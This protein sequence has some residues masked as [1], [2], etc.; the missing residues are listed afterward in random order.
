MEQVYDLHQH[1][2]FVIFYIGKESIDLRLNCTSIRSGSDQK[3]TELKSSC[4]IYNKEKTEIISYGDSE[5]QYD[6]EEHIR[7]DNFSDKLYNIFRKGKNYWDENDE[8]I[9]KAVSDFIRL[10]VSVMLERSKEKIDSTDELHYALVIP[11]EWEDEIREEIIRP[12]FV[13]SGLISSNDH[14]DRLLFYT[15]I[16]VIIYYLQNMEDGYTFKRGQN[17]ILCRLSTIDHDDSVLIDFDLISTMN[18]MFNFTNSRLF[19]KVT[20]STSLSVTSDDIKNGIKSYLKTQSLISEDDK[21]I[22][23][24]AEDV[25]QKGSQEENDYLYNIDLMRLLITDTSNW[26]LNDLQEKFIRSIRP[27][28]VCAEIGQSIIESMKDV[29][30]NK[31]SKD[32]E[33]LV[34]EDIYSSAWKKKLFLQNYDLSVMKPNIS[35]VKWLKYI[36]EYNRRSLNAITTMTKNS[37]ENDQISLSHIFSGADFGVHEAIQNADMNSLPRIV[38]SNNTAISPSIFQ[39]SKPNAIFNIDISLDSTVLYCSVISNEGLIQ[40]IIG[41]DYFT[42]DKSLPSL[43]SFYK[44]SN[45]A[46]L[47]VDNK[48]ISFAEEYFLDGF[49]YL[50]FDGDV[51]KKTDFVSRIEEILVKDISTAKD[52]TPVKRR[53]QIKSFLRTYK[54]Y[55]KDTILNREEI[56][57]PTY[58]TSI[59]IKQKK[60]INAFML[61]YMI[62]IKELICSSLPS[63]LELDNTEIKIGYAISIENILL[64]K[65]IGSKE[66]LQNIV[67]TSGLIKENDNSRKL[68]I[69]KQGERLLPVIKKLL[70]VNLPINSFFVIAQLREDYIQLTMHKVVIDPSSE[71]EQEAIIHEDEV[72]YI[73]NIYDSLCSHMWDNITKDSSWIEFCNLHNSDEKN[74]TSEL[75][76][77]KIQIEFANNFK[78]YISSHILGTSSPYQ[79]T[80]KNTVWLSSSCSCKINVTIHDVIEISF[81]PVLQDLAVTILSSLINK[82][83]FG[84]YL[85][86]QHLFNLIHFNKNPQFQDTI[87]R[88]LEEEVDTFNRV[89]GIDTSWFVIPVLP[90]YVLQPVINQQHFLYKEFQTGTLHQIFA[91]NYTLRI[92]IYYQGKEVWYEDN[93]TNTDQIEFVGDYICPIVKK[94]DMLSNITAKKTFY[95]RNS[96]SPDNIGTAAT[97][98]YKYKQPYDLKYDLESGLEN[99]TIRRA[100]NQRNFRGISFANEYHDVPLIVSISHLGHSSSLRISTNLVGVHNRENDFSEVGEPVT[101]ARH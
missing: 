34:L 68:R 4:I 25:Y 15:N 39:N 95:V 41:H 17:T 88:I 19:P 82:R 35:L 11:S 36:L 7:V 31:F 21:I 86:V 1:P 60:F 2:Y 12:L 8:F 90:A 20:R 23:A 81:K 5:F 77:L 29:V 87:S 51:T 3:G 99:N 75:L 65:I 55:I 37:L 42:A 71:D 6:E 85:N 91:E 62:Y 89:Q 33:L 49:D 56:S 63:L 52:V 16:E 72:I 13:Y 74:V 80:N 96:T 78:H 92:F 50:S 24:I 67:Y 53:T 69:I 73:D 18:N 28:D 43:G 101:L 47:N 100:V 70:G 30:S 14:L 59:S 10:E 26:E 79:N 54:N 40:K 27:F 32:Y 66:N 83:L 57:T 9:M 76:S 64:D 45:E 84:K 97:N 98:V 48:F 94:N 22:Q 93:E 61:M 38:S 58:E 44:I 46:T